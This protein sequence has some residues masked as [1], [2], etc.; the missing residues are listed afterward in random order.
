MVSSE[1]IYVATESTDCLNRRSSMLPLED[2]L[3]TR[4]PALASLRDTVIGFV[5]YLGSRF[6][7][8]R[9]LRFATLW[10]D[11]FDTY[12]R[13][14]YCICLISGLEVCLGSTAS[15]RDTVIGFVWYVPG[16]EVCLGS[17]ASRFTTALW[18]DFLIPGLEVC[19]VSTATVCNKGCCSLNLSWRLIFRLHPSRYNA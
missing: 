8:V 7:W 12:S 17:T 16:L 6:D 3:R 19:L 13:H 5:W 1:K 2:S 4:W 15:R 11:L 14:G 10:L 18:F 9:L